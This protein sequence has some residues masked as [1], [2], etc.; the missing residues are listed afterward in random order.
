MFFWIQNYHFDVIVYMLDKVR[1]ETLLMKFSRQGPKN[2]KKNRLSAQINF[3][4]KTV[5][6]P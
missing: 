4:K 3:N 1:L 5:Q 2:T 6:Y